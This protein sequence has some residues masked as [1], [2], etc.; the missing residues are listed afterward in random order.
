MTTRVMVLDP[1]PAIRAQVIGLL[2]ELGLEAE[3][4]TFPFQVLE[5]MSQPEPPS[6]LIVAPELGNLSGNAMLALVRSLRPRMDTQVINQPERE[7][8]LLE[9]LARRLKAAR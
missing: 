4:A 1:R 5:R 2:K 7:R 6:A 8:G 9:N 3:A